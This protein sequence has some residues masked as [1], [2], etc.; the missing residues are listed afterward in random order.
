MYQDKT[1][2]GVITARGGSKGIPRKNIKDF[3]G[4]PLIARTIKAAQQSAFLDLFVV[5]TDDDEIAA[6]A[7]RFGARAPFRRPAELA[8]DTAGSVAA[9]QH[10]VTWIKD[11]EGRSFDYVMILQPTSPLRT[12][13]DIDACIKKIIETGAD[14]VMSMVELVDFSIAKLKILEGDRIAPF[15]SPE[16][17]T[18]SRRDETPKLYKRNCAVYLTRTELIMA[19]DLFGIDSR[20]Y[21]MP[22]DRSVDINTP[23]D[24]ELAQYFAAKNSS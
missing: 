12:A 2:L 24:F 8:T 7:E 6:V 14:S 9:V 3:L 17:R 20:A 22:P 21:L 23:F 11:R 1:V 19:G 18:S 16:G 4:E 10:A 5:S 13:D 15:V